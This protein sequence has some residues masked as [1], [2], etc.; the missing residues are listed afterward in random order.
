MIVPGFVIFLWPSTVCA[1]TEFTLSRSH[2]QAQ[3]PGG[4]VCPT[5][6]SN[7]VP[8]QGPTNQ[9][10]YDRPASIHLHVAGLA[11]GFRLQSCCII[12]PNGR[13]A[14]MYSFVS[15]LHAP[16]QCNS[17]GRCWALFSNRPP[18]CRRLSFVVCHLSS[19]FVVRHSSAERCPD[20]RPITT[21][22]N[23][24]HAPLPPRHNARRVAGRS[25]HPPCRRPPPQHPLPRLRL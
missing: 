25:S 15:C 17:N 9:P 6:G 1:G 16:F 7:G 10:E 13:L 19:S 23:L 4:V 5:R 24:D 3:V 14:C 20:V 2:R 8:N 22:I 18:R 12:D 21:G 11:T